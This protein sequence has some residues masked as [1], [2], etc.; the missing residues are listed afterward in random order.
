MIELT[1]LKLELE[2][3]RNRFDQALTTGEIDAS[4]ALLAEAELQYN[5]AFC[6]KK[7]DTTKSGMIPQKT[8]K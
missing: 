4:I 2:K 7:N 5:A 1:S 3:A 6:K 8:D